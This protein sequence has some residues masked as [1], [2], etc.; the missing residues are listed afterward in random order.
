MFGD[1]KMIQEDE[2]IKKSSSKKNLWTIIAFFFAVGSWIYF[3]TGSDTAIQ[4]RN[5][6]KAEEHNKIL[7]KKFA[8]F[9]EFAE[10]YVGINTGAGGCIYI[11]GS[12]KTKEDLDLLKKSTIETKPDVKVLYCI[13]IEE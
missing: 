11:Y 5:L 13:S 12:V 2:K 10:V 7:E 6:A 9:K 8:T 3:F 4:M 1:K